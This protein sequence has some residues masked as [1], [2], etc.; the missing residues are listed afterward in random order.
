LT[1]SCSKSAA[2]GSARTIL[3]RLAGAKGHIR[4]NGPNGAFHHVAA[5]IPLGDYPISSPFSISANRTRR[6]FLR[7]P[8]P[9][10][11]V[12]H[13]PK[14]ISSNARNYN[15]GFVALLAN[16]AR[17]IDSNNNP[18]QIRDSR[19][20][21]PRPLDHV[22]GPKCA[23]HILEELGLQLLPAKPRALVLAKDLT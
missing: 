19:G 5:E 11:R 22:E 10:N 4:I 6:P 14:S 1:R 23:L 16:R 21:N 12:E 8:L 18:R 15:S 20:G 13:I 17:R 9:A 3:P 7:Q 2:I